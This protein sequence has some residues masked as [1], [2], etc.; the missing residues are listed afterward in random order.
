M[1]TIALYNSVF[2]AARALLY[3]DGV[4]EKS[5]YCLQ[6][7]IEQ[8]YG[9][10]K[11]LSS[12]ELSLFDLLRGLRQE[13]QYNVTRVKIDEDLDELYNKAEGFVERVKGLL[14]RKAEEGKEQ[15]DENDNPTK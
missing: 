7:Y 6:K 12:E 9:K 1:A 3:K 13:V 5:H 2:H 15:P 10:T 11:K 8:E 14:V 4:R